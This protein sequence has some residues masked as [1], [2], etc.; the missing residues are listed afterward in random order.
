MRHGRALRRRYGRA[1]GARW[2]DH[3]IAEDVTYVEEYVHNHG[4][5]VGAA[6]G[7]LVGAVIGGGTG[8]AVGAS[9]GALAGGGVA[10]ALK[11]IR[12]DGQ[13]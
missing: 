11:R 2:Y 1:Q 12:R 13:V 9:I 4:D 7:A 6:A 3:T 5:I 8:G 10:V